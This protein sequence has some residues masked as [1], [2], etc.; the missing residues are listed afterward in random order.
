WRSRAVYSAAACDQLAD[1]GITRQHAS[2]GDL[3]EHIAQHREDGEAVT[4]TSNEEARGVNSSIRDERVKRGE[5]DDRRT[6]YGSDGLPI[7]V[8]DLIQTRKNNTSIGVANRQQ[9]V[10][11]HVADDGALS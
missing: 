5:V 3:R 9:W 2:S 1:T 6:V 7:G 10:V 4:V 8:G 11:Q